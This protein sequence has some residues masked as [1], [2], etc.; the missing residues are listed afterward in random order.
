MKES[1]EHGKLKVVKA[2]A[3]LETLCGLYGEKKLG[4]IA[5]FDI[6]EYLDKLEHRLR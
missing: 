4:E 5:G 6:E 3:S 1:V 2:K